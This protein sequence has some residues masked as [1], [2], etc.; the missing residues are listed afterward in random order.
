[1]PHH[2]ITSPILQPTIYRYHTRSRSRI[3]H[4]SEVF[5]PHRNSA[6]TARP[7]T[8]GILQLIGQPVETLVQAIAA[9]GARRLNVPVSVS[10]RVQAQLVGDLGGVHCVRQILC[11]EER[12][13]GRLDHYVR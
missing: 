12:F 6:L 7:L 2:A 5:A 9:G 1:M 8:V 4:S 13:G 10:Q 3:N 11:T